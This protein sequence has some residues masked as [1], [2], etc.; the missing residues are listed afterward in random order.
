LNL[1]KQPNRWSC[2]PTALAMVLNIPIKDI[3][4]EIGHDGSEIIR[5]G[6][7]EPYNRKGFHLQDILKICLHHNYAL[8]QFDTKPTIL[9]D[10]KVSTWGDD[11]FY[12][13]ELMKMYDGILFGYVNNDKDHA[14][15][16]NHLDHCIYDPNGTIYMKMFFNIESFLL[17]KELK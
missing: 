11:T 6:E 3:I 13:N 5:P 15:A 2:I 9:Y 8:M 1:I 10:N 17:I 14:V 4:I 16:W 12:V 7:L